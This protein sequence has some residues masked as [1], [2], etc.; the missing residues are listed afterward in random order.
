MALPATL[1]APPVV[2]PFFLDPPLLLPPLLY[3][4]PVVET[5]LLL[6]VAEVPTL[7][8]ER[9]VLPP[10]PPLAPPLKLLFLEKEADDVLLL[11]PPL[12]PPPPLAV[13]LVPLLTLRLLPPLSDDVMDV[14][15]LLAVEV[16]ELAERED[17]RLPL[18]FPT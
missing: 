7:P 2:A 10:P 4:L 13:L 12:L 9:S 8:L 15:E 3:R 18:S 17:E 5:P 16:P 1:P 11:P 14:A 6:P